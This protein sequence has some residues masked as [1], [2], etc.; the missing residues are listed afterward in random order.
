MRRIAGAAITAETSIASP[1][2]AGTHAG[3]DP[4]APKPVIDPAHQAAVEAGRSQAVIP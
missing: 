3:H 2:T 1:N 4:P